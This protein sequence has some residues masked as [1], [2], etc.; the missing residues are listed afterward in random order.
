LNAIDGFIFSADVDSLGAEE[1]INGVDDDLVWGEKDFLISPDGIHL[2]DLVNIDVSFVGVSED[3][4]FLPT[5]GIEEFNFFDGFLKTFDKEVLL[6]SVEGFFSSNWWEVS[7]FNECNSDKSLE[8]RKTDFDLFI[9]VD[10]DISTSLKEQVLFRVN[11]LTIRNWGE[12]E[13][14]N[15]D[16]DDCL[17]LVDRE[18]SDTAED[19]FDSLILED[20]GSLD[21]L[22]DVFNFRGDS[23]SDISGSPELS[24][25][26]VKTVDGE[27]FV[28]AVYTAGGLDSFK[29]GFLN[30]LEDVLNFR[31]D[32]FTRSQHSIDSV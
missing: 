4:H 20:I 31:G 28:T 15:V 9:V 22:E 11:G 19:G 6:I 16:D 3:L 2:L 5:L 8:L 29:I 14:S 23:L 7:L 27:A 13:F 21:T 10:R 17:E 26:C 24:K 18:R 25:D 1:F 30:T 32:S 12:V